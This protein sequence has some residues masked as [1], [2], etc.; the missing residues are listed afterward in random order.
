[1]LLLSFKTEYFLF[2]LLAFI[3]K[4]LQKYVGFN[5]LS[6]WIA[7]AANPRSKQV[8]HE[9][10]CCRRRFSGRCVHK[11]GN[12]P[13]RQFANHLFALLIFHTICVFPSMKF[14]SVMFSLDLQQH[15]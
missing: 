14:S 15:E 5:G 9:W 8:F 6:S 10:V 4:S 1:M 11:L 3:L 12:F 7:Y 13:R 2:V